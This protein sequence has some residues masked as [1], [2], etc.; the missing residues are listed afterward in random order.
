MIDQLR[1]E[2]EDCEQER[3]ILRDRAQIVNRTLQ[4]Y[5][6]QQYDKRHKK[7]TLYK[8]GDLVMIKVLQHKPGTNKKLAPKFKGPYQVKAVLNKN[9][10]VIIDIPVYNLTQKPLNTIIS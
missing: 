1:N 5:N 8:S 7:C 9:R 10:Y 4:E 6:K 2:S 3:H